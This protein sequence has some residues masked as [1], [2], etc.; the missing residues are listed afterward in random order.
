MFLRNSSHLLA[1]LYYTA[2]SHAL[3]IL[4]HTLFYGEATLVS[5]LRQTWVNC[6]RQ[7]GPKVLSLGQKC[8]IVLYSFAIISLLFDLIKQLNRQRNIQ[9][10]GNCILL[11]CLLNSESK[12]MIICECFLLGKHAFGKHWKTPHRTPWVTCCCDSR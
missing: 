12:F 2:P 9:K 8:L 10:K 5:V 11:C 4:H 3:E 1:G 7:S 6:Y